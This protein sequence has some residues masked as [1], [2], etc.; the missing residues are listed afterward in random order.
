MHGGAVLSVCY[1]SLNASSALSFHSNFAC[2]FV[3]VVV[4]SLL[5]L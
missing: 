2:F 1:K 4:F 3:V 5:N